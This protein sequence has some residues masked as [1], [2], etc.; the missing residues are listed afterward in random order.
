MEDIVLAVI[1]IAFFLAI[2]WQF[3][4]II[5]HVFIVAWPAWI[6]V[7]ALTVGIPKLWKMTNLGDLTSPSD[8]AELVDVSITNEGVRFKP[9]KQAIRNRVNVTVAREVGVVL[10]LVVGVI[11]VFAQNGLGGFASVSYS[12]NFGVGVPSQGDVSGG[13]C[14]FISLALLPL[15]VWLASAL[16]KTEA[17]YNEIEQ[18]ISELADSGRTVVDTSRLHK[19]A[20]RVNAAAKALGVPPPV[21]YD[22]KLNALIEKH[23]QSLLSGSKAFYLALDFLIGEANEDYEGLVATGKLYET[24]MGLYEATVRAVR[25]A[26]STALLH[27]LESNKYYSPDRDKGI[28][29]KM[30]ANRA[31]GE[32]DGALRESNHDLKQI[33]DFARLVQRGES[34][35]YTDPQP[36]RSGSSDDGATELGKAYETLGLRP[37][38]TNHEVAHRLKIL[39]LTIAKYA[40]D[41]DDEAKQVRNKLSEQ[42]GNAYKIIKKARGS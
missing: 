21:D 7:I 40:P 16:V 39:R 34:S 5:V 32:L 3:V 4:V 2:G 6:A 25:E 15:V 10:A 22:R 23:K 42:Y 11:F 35:D 41:D 33:Y 18:R 20:G 12:L 36:P 14:V 31:W 37:T 27:Q 38:A 13:W 30:V 24:T 19:L 9:V 26:Q 29:N 1:A 8:I 17:E 28:L